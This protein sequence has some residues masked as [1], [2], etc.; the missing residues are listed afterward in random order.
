MFDLLRPSSNNI[1]LVLTMIPVAVFAFKVAL[2]W[3]SE[4]FEG[5]F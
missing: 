3:V 5:I 2:D 4:Q 1:V